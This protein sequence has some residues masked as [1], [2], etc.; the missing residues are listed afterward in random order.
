[1]AVP[2]HMQACDPLSN[3]P[4]RPPAGPHFARRSHH[5]QTSSNYKHRSFEFSS[6]GFLGWCCRLAHITVRFI[7][8]MLQWISEQY[9]TWTE[10][11]SAAVS[12]IG[13]LRLTKGQL[14]RLFM[15][16]TMHDLRLHLNDLAGPTWAPVVLATLLAL[17]FGSFLLLA[18][19]VA[20]S[21]SLGSRGRK[22][23][24]PILR[25]HKGWD[26]PTLLKEGAKRY[27]NSPYIITYSGYEYVVFPSSS[28]DEV[29][30]LNAS[31]ASMVDWF[32]QVFWQ[33]WTF[34]GT[35]NS[36]RY[37]TVGIDLARALPSRVWMRQD[38]AQ[39]AFE[40]VLGPHGTIKDWTTVSLWGTV[41]KIV[42]LMNATGLLGPELVVDSRWLKATQR[43]HTA[44]MI[45]IVGSHLTPRFLRPMVA[46]IVFLP[47]KLVDLHMKW[48]LRPMVQRELDAYQAKE[49]H[50]GHGSSEHTKSSTALSDRVGS[51]G[52]SGNGSAQRSIK[53]KFP[54]TEW[55]LDRYRSHDGRLNHLLR[56][57]IV[58]AFEAATT[59]SGMLYFLLA[60]LA[61]RPDLVGELR[62]ELE[63]N[64]DE[65]GHLPLT[66]LA[67]LRKMDSFMLESARVTG[68]SHCMLNLVF[69]AIAK[70]HPEA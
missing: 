65:S 41:Q 50:P 58:I 22:L 12:A 29:K 19:R 60:E 8:I 42:S 46:P 34:L 70:T 2:S 27:P 45:G 64:T 69:P 47:A 54:L 16:K 68:S 59:S 39:A 25:M 61:A 7:F 30:R 55:L 17:T 35:D 56:D 53:E 44:L 32:T 9:A 33:G 6:N 15:R 38:N 23:Q 62:V 43:L 21:F 28:F 10:Q 52:A 18:L 20:D 37:H 24:L 26:Y 40:A 11:L 63:R 57:H 5:E 67:E 48:L 3:T 1:M 51:S 31:R 13:P 14:F 66:Y 49:T 4:P 36:A